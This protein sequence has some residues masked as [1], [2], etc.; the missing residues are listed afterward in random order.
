[1]QGAAAQFDKVNGVASQ[2]PASSRSA[3]TALIGAVRPSLEDLFTKVLA[4]PGVAEIAKPTI[5]GV[6]AN[7]DALAR[8]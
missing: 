7:L 2:L 6:R 3:L 8:A 5:D 1:M 4:I